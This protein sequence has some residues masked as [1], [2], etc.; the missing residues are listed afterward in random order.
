MTNREI[1][2]AR[3]RELNK[4]RNTLSGAEKA[5]VTIKI[6]KIVKQARKIENKEY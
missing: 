4:I 5:K 1:T 6:N 2:R 3:L